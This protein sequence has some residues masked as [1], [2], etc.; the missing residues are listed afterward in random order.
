MS[1][2]CEQLFFELFWNLSAKKTFPSILLQQIA[3]VARPVP[4]KFLSYTLF[5]SLSLSRTLGDGVDEGDG[6]GGLSKLLIWHVSSSSSGTLGDGVD[7][8]DGLGGRFAAVHLYSVCVCVCVHG[9]VSLE[10]E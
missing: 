2:V 8:A 5:L 6:L 4:S 3:D 10:L 7:E 9:A 1:S